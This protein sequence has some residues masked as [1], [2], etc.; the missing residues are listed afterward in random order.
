MS[1][2]TTRRQPQ[3]VCP[4]CAHVMTY[5]ELIA[6]CADVNAVPVDLTRLA[7]DEA[8]AQIYCVN[9]ECGK[10]FWINGG[11]AAFYTTAVDQDDV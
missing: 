8:M 5:D 2:L 9:I 7:P 6:V 3:P 1:D 10:P 11:F 4:T